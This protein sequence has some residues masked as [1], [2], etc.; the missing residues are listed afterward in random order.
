MILNRAQKG[1]N[2]QRY[3]QETIINTLET[4]DYCKSEN[5]KGVLVSVDQS[6]AFDS[7]SHTFMEKVYNFWGFGYRIKNWLKSIG[8]GRTACIILGQ[9]TMGDIFNLGKG[10][11]QGDSPSPLL[12]NFAAQIL[13]FKIELDAKIKNIHPPKLR[14]GPIVPISPFKHESNRETDKSDCFADDNT[15]GTLLEIGSLKRL[16]EILSSFKTLSSLSTNYEKT[17]LMGIG[18]LEGEIS[19]N[20]L[21]F[22]IE[23][24]LNCLGTI[25]LIMTTFWT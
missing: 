10:H 24:Q 1:F 5:I 14:P 16:K 9:G 8:T 4:I 3:I 21:G 19:E 25:Y 22:S 23:Q 15:V 17:A 7:V 11:A 20:D 2:Q 18:N 6:K 12:Y 13:L